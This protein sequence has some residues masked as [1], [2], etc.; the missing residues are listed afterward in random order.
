[1]NASEIKDLLLWSAAVNYAVLV[2]WMV[3][4]TFAHG[5]LFRLHSRWFRISEP[6]FD[7]I[8]YAGM[9]VYKILVLVFNVAPLLAM[10]MTGAGALPGA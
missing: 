7:A 6:A 1:M 2:I 5:W 8:H 10:I 3:A 4:F 9:A